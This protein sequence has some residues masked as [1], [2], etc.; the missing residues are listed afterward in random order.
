MPVPAP[1]V[2]P[3]VTG[4][5]GGRRCACP[6]CDLLIGLDDPQCDHCGAHITPQMRE[7]MLEAYQKNV[8]S[9]VPVVAVLLALVVLLVYLAIRSL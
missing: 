1:P 5:K 6:R 4:G 9:T 2:P 8:Q 3:P 7:E